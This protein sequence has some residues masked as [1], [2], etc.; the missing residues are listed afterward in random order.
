MRN[1]LSYEEFTIESNLPKFD[2]KKAGKGAAI[3][4]GAGA[5]LGGATTMYANHRKNKENGTKGGLMKNVGK[6]TL[7]L[8]AAGAFTGGVIGGAVLPS[9]KRATK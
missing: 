8:G 6:N 7:A 3:G 5:F 9:A 2:Y 1:I 4:A